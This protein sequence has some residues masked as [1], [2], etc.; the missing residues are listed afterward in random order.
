MTNDSQVIDNFESLLSKLSNA[1]EERLD[2][3]VDERGLMNVC[4][5]CVASEMVADNETALLQD[6]YKAGKDDPQLLLSV[7]T[8][9]L[10]HTSG[11]Q[12]L[13]QKVL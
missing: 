2:E 9:T 11:L 6:L 7:I 4:A 5:G 10:F 8:K 13:L 12:V 3:D 1:L